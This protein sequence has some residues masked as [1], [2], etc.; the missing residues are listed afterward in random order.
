M[1]QDGR[2]GWQRGLE[3]KM[4][5]HEHQ[6]SKHQPA[7]R[8]EMSRRQFLSYTLGGTTAFMVGGAVLPMVRFAVDPLLA[9]GS[10]NEL[11]KVIEESK[12]TNEPQEVKFTINQVDGWYKGKSEKVAWISKDASGN[13]F[14]L[15]PV[16]KHLGCTV[17]WNTHGKNEYDC[18][19]HDAR[20]SIDGKNLAVANSP[21][22]EYQV[23]V[24]DGYV[25]L[26]GIIPNTRA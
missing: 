23:A 7:Q 18:P 1:R 19:C 8:N 5:N 13:V 6:D 4:S 3:Q 25:Y 2:I 10:A 17:F 16:C 11:V 12:V 14:A 22:D 15:S 9:K 24:Q 21:L 26:G 20:Y